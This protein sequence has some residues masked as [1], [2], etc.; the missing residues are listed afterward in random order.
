MLERTDAGI[1]QQSRLFKGATGGRGHVQ[2]G[3]PFEK[4]KTNDKK[5]T[6]TPAVERKSR[7]G[8][9]IHVGGGETSVG[10]DGGGASRLLAV[11][12]HAHPP[13]A[14]RESAGEMGRGSPRGFGGTRVWTDVA[15]RPS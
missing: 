1:W 5:K 12:V 10:G 8:T 13:P 9:E 2:D 15:A 3:D 7:G 6:T 14:L 4:T 11:H